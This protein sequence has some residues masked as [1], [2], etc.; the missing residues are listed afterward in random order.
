M[1][2]N[3]E[4]F[5]YPEVDELRCVSC[6]VC[7]QKCPVLAPYQPPSEET[8]RTYS[9]YRTDLVK[10]LESASGG[11]MS[12]LAEY[13]VRQGGVVYGVCYDEN[14]SKAEYVR[15]E[16]EEELE[17]MKSS[18][19]IMSEP[20]PWIYGRLEQDLKAGRQVLFTGC[21]CEAGA[22]RRFLDRGYENL[23][24]CELICQGATTPLALQQYVRDIERETGEKVATVNM[25]GKKDGK[26]FPH[27]MN[28]YFKN[29]EFLQK[30]GG[31]TGF[32]IC[33]WT[34][35]RPSCYRCRYKFPNSAADF[36]AGDHIGIN[37]GDEGFHEGGVSIV[38][39]HNEKAA[40]LL[41]QL[42]G[43]AVRKEVYEKAAGIQACLDKSIPES[44]FR[45]KF[46]ELLKSEGLAAAAEYEARTKQAFFDRT[47]QD[48]VDGE[49]A[50]R[51]VIWGVGKY[52]EMTYRAIVEKRPNVE[53]VGIVD[54]YKTGSRHGIELIPPRKLPEIDFDHVFIT[55]VNG[56]DE[57]VAF[58]SKI[59]PEDGQR[60]YTLCIIPENFS[61]A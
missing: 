4:G 56:K 12:A 39:A 57:A 6:G 45:N 31:G 61:P 59:F 17:R 49:K 36:T 7:T 5:L 30:K 32:D 50:V 53:I 55:T 48:A 10:L 23:L 40:R 24:V 42:P 51:C 35:K 44:A 33:F 28:T 13:V 16:T 14:C 38:F 29:G 8:P 3:E 52:F 19:Y 21:P 34:V 47:V 9:G 11:F 18:K 15:G 2:R 25:R 58:L 46:L 1:R 54:K 41:E 20:Q 60:R 43:F 22:A 26:A 27:Q 37:P